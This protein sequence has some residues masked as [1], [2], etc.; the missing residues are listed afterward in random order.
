VKPRLE[1]RLW[2]PAPLRDRAA[3]CGGRTSSSLRA[4]QFLD[5][6]YGLRRSGL[7]RT[8]SSIRREALLRRFGCTGVCNLNVKRFNGVWKLNGHGFLSF[9]SRCA[10]S[11]G[12]AASIARMKKVSLELPNGKNVQK[13]SGTYLPR[14]ENKHNA[15]HPPRLAF[16]AGVQVSLEGRWKLCDSLPPVRREDTSLLFFLPILNGPSRPISQ[17]MLIQPTPANWSATAIVRRIVHHQV[18]PKGGIW[19]HGMGDKSCVPLLTHCWTW[20]E[21][22]A[23]PT[24][25]VRHEAIGRFGFAETRLTP[26]LAE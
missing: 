24:G 25:A 12:L 23:A 6:R 7:R 20:A 4:I 18:P 14:T 21:G 22:R 11:V 9:C 5:R 19:P 8:R 2:P 10:I 16:E 15:S 17:K 13:G 3:Q 26:R 1:A